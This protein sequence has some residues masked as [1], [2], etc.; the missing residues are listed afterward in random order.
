MIDLTTTLF[1]VNSAQVLPTAG[2]LLISDPFSNDRI[3]RHSVISV[4]DHLSTEGT[5]GVVMNNPAGYYLDDV[6]DGVP[7]DSNIP[8]YCGGPLGQNRLY[9]LHTLG[10]EIIPGAR[11]YAPGM[12]VGGDFD[13]MIDIIRSGYDIQGCVRF[14]IGYSSW[15]A[16][17]L[18]GEI[19]NGSWAL[20]GSEI[21]TSDIF[22]GSGDSYW[23]RIVRRM[24]KSFRAWSLI[25]KHVI[26]N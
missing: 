8:V 5:T 18:E 15:S 23:H 13:A 1:R 24:G 12:Y 14:F 6:L 19:I 21:S 25:P 7:K 4:I 2:T 9:F 20:A 17:Q 22:D 10:S 11:E 16:G 3:F 26:N